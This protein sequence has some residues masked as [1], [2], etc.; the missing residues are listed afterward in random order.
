VAEFNGI[1]QIKAKKEKSKKFCKTRCV[2][3]NIDLNVRV[4]SLI[5]LLLN[6]YVHVK[7]G[8]KRDFNRSGIT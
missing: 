3:L 7:E 5:L 8:V 6:T 1:Y 4:Y 2:E